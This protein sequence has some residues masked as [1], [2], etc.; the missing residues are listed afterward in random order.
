MHMRG[1]FL[2]LYGSLLV[3]VDE[4]TPSLVQNVYIESIQETGWVVN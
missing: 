2:L 4:R 3:V 1:F